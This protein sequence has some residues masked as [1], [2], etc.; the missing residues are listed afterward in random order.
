MTLFRLLIMI[1]ALAILATPAATGNVTS[2]LP[3]DS[4]SSEWQRYRVEG[5]EFSVLLPVLPAMST[6]EMFVD[7]RTTRRERILGSYE[8]GVVY[9][10]YTFEKRGISLDQLISKFSPGQATEAATIDGI[11]GR[12]STYEA[13]EFER[14]TKFVAT[15]KNLYVF[16]SA[17]SKLGNVSAGT[18]RFFDSIKFKNLEGIK[19]QDGVGDQMTSIT[20][21]SSGAIFRSAEVTLKVK[22]I[23]KPEPRY[24]E[25]AR[26]NGVTGTVVLRTVFSSSGAVKNLAVIKGLPDG[27]TENALAAAKQIRFIPAIKDGRFVSMWMQLE[28]N[29]NLY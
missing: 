13:Q 27:L 28:Y 8:N 26:M 25:P 9:A 15:T 21:T 14:I 18:T 1:V 3:Q 29:F 16:Q 5:E 24:T 19:L 17:G 11:A 6:T 22:V 10:V 4:V 2:C 20:D 7:L 23:T 12:S